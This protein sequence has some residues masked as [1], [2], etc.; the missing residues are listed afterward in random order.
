MQHPVI[1]L[2]NPAPPEAQQAQV[3]AIF[4][5]VEQHLGFVPDGLRLYGIS[6]P[7]LEAFVG[8]VA[9]FREGTEVRFCVARKLEM[10]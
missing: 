3:E 4:G 5:Q 9:Y 1:P 2:L 8:N 7:L 6:P 10:G